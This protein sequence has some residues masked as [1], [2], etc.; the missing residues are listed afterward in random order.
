M[1]E[2]DP[3]YPPAPAGI[4][5]DLTQPGWRYRWQVFRVLWVLFLFLVVFV[6]LL[7]VA[8]L[9]MGWGVWLLDVRDLDDDSW[10]VLLGRMA[11][12]VGFLFMGTTLVA[13][14]LKC[15]F[16][17]ADANF[18]GYVE[19]TEATQPEL[20]QFVRT[21]CG[22]VGCAMP[23]RVYLDH[24]VNAGIVFPMSGWRLIIPPPKSLLIGLGLV[25]HLNV[26][27]FKALLAHEL[28]H[29]SQRCMGLS[30]YAVVAHRV[31]SEELEN[32]R[33]YLISFDASVFGWQHRLARRLGKQE[34]LCDRYR[35]HSELQRLA[36]SIARH[37]A[38]VHAIREYLDSAGS[39]AWEQIEQMIDNSREAHADLVCIQEQAWDLLLPP[40]KHLEAGA[41]LRRLLP[42]PCE[43][44][45]LKV[46]HLI[47]DRRWLQNL[48]QTLQQTLTSLSELY[49]KSLVELLAF[50]DR[51][52][53]AADSRRSAVVMV[54]APEG[55]ADQ[56]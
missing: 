47:Q 20:F 17:R 5:A 21:V 2:A 52:V 49:Q 12:G 54:E 36:Q 37:T 6:I 28:G 25:E 35:F 56:R 33:R 16:R 22:E 51:S 4:P 32:D 50:P 31:V 44:P 19:I 45:D 34:E 1:S 14:L 40:L 26:V 53:G 41:P 38:M 3:L 24:A 42:E 10:R 13:Y 43:F 11:L 23:G 39:L 9:F 29:F 46:A 30:G 18:P 15:F 8:G 55:T 7:G 48:D 27:E